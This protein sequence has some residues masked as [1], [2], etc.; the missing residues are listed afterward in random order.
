MLER[1]GTE[2]L[3]PGPRPG[4]VLYTVPLARS[5]PT[6][7]P[8]YFH[9]PSLPY[10]H[11]VPGL[12]HCWVPLMPLT[13]AHYPPVAS[14]FTLRTLRRSLSLSS[15]FSFSPA[16]IPLR[17]WILLSIPALVFLLRVLS[18]VLTLQDPSL[19]R[20]FLFCTAVFGALL[21]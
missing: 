6:R 10:L 18:A 8:V 5:L 20:A 16:S 14:P 9:S 17:C 11:S 13:P 3:V 2:A 7:N 1:I 21:L 15:P 4:P 12:N 19:A